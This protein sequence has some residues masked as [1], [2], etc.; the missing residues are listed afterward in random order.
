[1]RHLTTDTDTETN[2]YIFISRTYCHECHDVSEACQLPPAVEVRLCQYCCIQ[3]YQPKVKPRKRRKGPIRET[4][5][6]LQPRSP[7][8]SE[9]KSKIIML[10]KKSMIR[11]TYCSN[12]STHSDDAQS[13]IQENLVT[14]LL[15]GRSG[16]A[17]I[18][19]IRLFPSED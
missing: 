19:L 3:K 17:Q 4:S 7:K 2:R 12:Q 9:Q 10:K 5:T 15:I 1:M 6:V 8:P 18:N 13:Y 11:Q 14:I 16:R